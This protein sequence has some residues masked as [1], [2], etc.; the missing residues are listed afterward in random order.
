M[1]T[2]FVEFTEADTLTPVSVNP[3][4]VRNLKPLPGV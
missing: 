4:Y 1:S 3:D 2:K